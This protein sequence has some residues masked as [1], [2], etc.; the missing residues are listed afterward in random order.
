MVHAMTTRDELQRII[1]E[2][3][4]RRAAR[5]ARGKAE[6]PA[7]KEPID[8][9]RM[10]KISTTDALGI[11]TDA[12]LLTKLEELYYV[13]HPRLMTLAQLARIVE[14]LASW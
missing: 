11:M 8:L 9:D 1:R 10:K 12:E 4:Q 13:D 14:E 6:A 7:G 5:I 3:E 2:N